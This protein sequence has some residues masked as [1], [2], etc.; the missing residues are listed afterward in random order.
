MKHTVAINT[1]TV[2]ELPV[3]ALQSIGFRNESAT[4]AVWVYPGD[5][6]SS[7]WNI[8]AQGY[9]GTT[10]EQRAQF[11]RWN[12][13]KI[14]PGEQI[15]FASNGRASVPVRWSATCETAAVELHSLPEV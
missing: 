15:S 3:G 13:Y 6:P 8:P 10:N 12:G 4:Q 7:L 1:V 14:A 11:V 9:T 5:V 2:V